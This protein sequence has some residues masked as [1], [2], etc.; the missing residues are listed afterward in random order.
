MSV[1]ASQDRP[2][3]MEF[4]EPRMCIDQ[5]V[6]VWTAPGSDNGEIRISFAEEGPNSVTLSLN[7]VDASWLAALLQMK[8]REIED[9]KP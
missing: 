6:R 2:P 4:A 3:L 9:A 7:R 8:L 1:I 5:R